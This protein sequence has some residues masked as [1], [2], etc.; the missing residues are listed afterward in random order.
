MAFVKGECIWILPYSGGMTL[1]RLLPSLRYFICLKAGDSSSPLGS[2]RA[3]WDCGR[4]GGPLTPP[5]L[6]PPDRLF[7]LP[8]FTP[9]LLPLFSPWA[10]GDKV[11]AR[12]EALPGGMCPS[13]WAR[14]WS[15]LP[16]SCVPPPPSAQMGSGG[17]PAICSPPSRLT[18]L[19]LPLS[20]LLKSLSQVSCHP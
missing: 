9:S 15:L 16:R 2:L 20:H 7:L 10:S 14:E 1:G 8:L 17:L 5:M 12:L 4:H 6:F 13:P 19:S 11:G 3:W 18:P